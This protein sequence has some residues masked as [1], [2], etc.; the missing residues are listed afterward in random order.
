MTSLSELRVQA[1][2][3]GI[4]DA[5][6][7]KYG[8]IRHKRTWSLAIEHHQL[9]IDSSPQIEPFSTVAFPPDFELIPI[10]DDSS[11]PLAA[12]NTA[13]SSNQQTESS[14]QLSSKISNLANQP[15]GWSQVVQNHLKSLQTLT[16][17][18][19]NQS[20]PI[21]N[22]R[23]PECQGK[24]DFNCYLCGGAGHVDDTAATAWTLAYM[25][26]LG[27]SPEEIQPLRN[28]DSGSNPLQLSL[29]VC[30]TI[31]ESAVLLARTDKWLKPRALSE[32]RN[33]KLG[34]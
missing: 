26:L 21:R 17:S 15:Q 1:E 18:Q 13:S 19:A 20:R 27:C 22:W 25:E 11:T 33:W 12:I 31:Q 34:N 8:D 32:E 3:L 9:T 5:E 2:V 16:L 6:V 23:C 14:T 29:Q 10:Q 28:S 30:Q 4:T 24:S 7:Q